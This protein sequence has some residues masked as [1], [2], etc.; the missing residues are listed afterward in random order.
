MCVMNVNIDVCYELYF[1]SDLR[2]LFWDETD[3]SINLYFLD[4]LLL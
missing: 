2:L 1:C 4:V 3:H